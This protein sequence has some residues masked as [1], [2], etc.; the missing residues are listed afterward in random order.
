VIKV[1]L[2][3][4]QHLV[5]QA[6]AALLSFEDDI[7][8]VGDVGTGDEV[9]DAVTRLEPDVVLLDIEMPGKDG[10]TVAAELSGVRVI[11]LTT[12]GRPGYLS[13]AVDAGVAG[14]VLKDARADELADAIR[15][16]AGGGRVIDRK[17][18]A[19][20]RSAGANPLTDRERDVLRAAADGATIAEIAQ[21]LFLSTGT[22][23]NYL[24][25]ASQKVGARNR[26]EAVR[27]AEDKGWL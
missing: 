23:R 24:S 12:F 6:M 3:D 17:L 19:A 15:K 13:R 7:T 26:A 1:L 11:I 9:A 18:A 10:L 4:D 14:Y 27:A 8:V 25:S 20:S 16:V 21:R 2:A 22:V 5:R